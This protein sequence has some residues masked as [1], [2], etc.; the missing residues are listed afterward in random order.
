MTNNEL[1][2]AFRNVE[3]E[4]DLPLVESAR[5]RHE[6][7][8]LYGINLSRVLTDSVVRE[9]GGYTTLS[10]GRVQGPTLNFVVEREQ[11][12]VLFVPTPFWVIE[13]QVQA[14]DRSYPVDYYLE[15]I[16][17]IG[18][19]QQIV[20]ECT[21]GTLKVREVET[22][23]VEQKPPY[24][25]DLSGLQSEAFRHLGFS[26][27]RT[28]AIAE[29]LYLDALI[30]Y[31]RTASQKLPP[32][33]GYANILH[34]LSSQEKFRHLAMR[35]LQKSTLRP[36]Q[37]LKDDPAHPAV[38]PTGETPARSLTDPEAKL[39]DLIVRRFLSTFAEPALHQ[40]QRAVLEKGQHTFYLR[41]STIEKLGWI[42]FYKPYA[43]AETLELPKLTVGDEVPIINIWNR[44][45]FTQPPPRFSSLG[46][47]R[48]MEDA[49]IGTKA[50]RAEII[51]ILYKRGYVDESRMKATLLATTVIG[52]L[53]KYC[54]PII[55]ASFT[56]ALEDSMAKIQEGETTRKI[57]LVKAVQ[58][59]RNVML[60]LIAHE[61]ELGSQLGGVVS[62]Q[63]LVD[64]WFKTPCPR[65]GARLRIARNRKTGKRF[66]GCTARWESNCRFTLPLPQ[67]GTLSIVG[68]TCRECGFQMVQARSRGRRA[69]V[70]CP[71]CYA[72]RH[73][74]KTSGDFSG[75]A[76][77]SLNETEVAT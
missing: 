39:Y 21:G 50:T 17:T 24:P 31:P 42:E 73:R 51:E 32:T 46:L 43:S 59:L 67:L 7:D 16:P 45:K 14:R 34:G 41:G 19:A 68:R 72:D 36:S 47:L 25:F 54:Q 44:E 12:I 11:E 64:S 53:G 8:W 55:D 29:R 40:T 5:C 3:S 33:I 66:I 57:V 26:P 63:K 2:K 27:A 13:T 61:E 22:R 56:A 9:N 71:R 62:H 49:G 1:K 30:S 35:L 70:S 58:H 52:L 60:E 4:L 74:A 48:R 15:K 23:L 76:R 20:S 37:G 38:Y 28:V 75:V 10:T 65:C 77:T 18:Q 6:L 69:L